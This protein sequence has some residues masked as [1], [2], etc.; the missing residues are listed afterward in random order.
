MQDKFERSSLGQFA[1]KYLPVSHS[2]LCTT[3][4]A[5]NENKVS[6]L[7]S[8]LMLLESIKL[9]LNSVRDRDRWRIILIEHILR[10]RGKNDHL[11][12]YI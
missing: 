7:F 2:I 9:N 4:V 8:V 3:S 10:A 5:R 12:T 11:V 1:I 6:F